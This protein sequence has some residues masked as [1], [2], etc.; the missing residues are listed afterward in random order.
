MTRFVYQLLPEHPMPVYTMNMLKYIVQ[1]LNILGFRT[2]VSSRGG[3]LKWL[4]DLDVCHVG[5]RDSEAEGGGRSETA[6]GCV[7][8]WRA[9]ESQQE[10]SEVNVLYHYI[11]VIMVRFTHVIIPPLVFSLGKQSATG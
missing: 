7:R 3:G 9:S 11:C 8:L 10:N 2:G 1:A 6:A 4:E 5:W